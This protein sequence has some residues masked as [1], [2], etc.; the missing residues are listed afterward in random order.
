MTLHRFAKRL[1]YGGERDGVG[2][3][4][5]LVGGEVGEESRS[6][7]GCWREG[8]LIAYFRIARIRRRVGKEHCVR[9]GVALRE[10]RQSQLRSDYSGSRNEGNWRTNH[11]CGKARSKRGKQCLNLKAVVV[12]QNINEEQEL[13]STTCSSRHPQPH[14]LAASGRRRNTLQLSC[15]AVLLRPHYRQTSLSELF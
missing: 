12:V 10:F 1:G 13:F 14:G 3:G 4:R 7:R 5:K 6:E 2:E 9:E 8:A 11:T 15:S